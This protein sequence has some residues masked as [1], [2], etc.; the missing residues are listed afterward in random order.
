M[1][2]TWGRHSRPCTTVPSATPLHAAANTALRWKGMSDEG[3]LSAAVQAQPHPGGPEASARGPRLD[4]E[5]RVIAVFNAGSSSLKFGLYAADAARTIAT[6]LVDWEADPKRAK[7]IVRR[8]G[9]TVES[10]HS[11]S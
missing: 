10:Q 1:R 5:R 3:G 11:V 6:G 2:R 8:D 7:L 9:A 4:R